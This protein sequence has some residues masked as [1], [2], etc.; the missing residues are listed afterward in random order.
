MDLDLVKIF[1]QKRRRKNSL[2]V[3][4]CDSKC[5]LQIAAVDRWKRP[6]NSA[7]KETLQTASVILSRPSSSPI[8][9]PIPPYHIDRQYIIRDDDQPPNNWQTSN[10]D[11]SPSGRVQ[12]MTLTRSARSVSLI[13]GP[14][15]QR[16]GRGRGRGRGNHR[17]RGQRDWSKPVLLMNRQPWADRRRGRKGVREEENIG[18][19][20]KACG[21]V[22]EQKGSDRLSANEMRR[23]RRTNGDRP[24]MART[25][26]A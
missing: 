16:I 4:V 12:A 2:N 25:I 1:A 15:E 9:F 8:Y 26:S 10:M 5:R 21:R 20:R 13:E 14:T 11:S 7:M 6:A 18:E 24:V 17:C 22:R 19:R 3:E 23:Q